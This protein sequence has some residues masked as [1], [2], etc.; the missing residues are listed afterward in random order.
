MFNY[1][2]KYEVFRNDIFIINVLDIIND[3]SL[4]AIL[5]AKIKDRP[6]LGK[7][8]RDGRR[9]LFEFNKAY[10][11]VMSPMLEK[12]ELEELFMKYLGYYYDLSKLECIF[13]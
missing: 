2:I 4:S 1:M 9:V 5:K 3:N 10:P 6:D 8:E 13:G 11:I 7:D 12:E